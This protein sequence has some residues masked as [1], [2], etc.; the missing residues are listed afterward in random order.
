MKLI[1][2]IGAMICTALATLTALVFCMAMGANSTPA[3]LRALKLWMGG[4]SLLGVAGIVVGIFLIRAGQ[5]SWA[6]IAAFA[7]TVIYGIILSTSLLK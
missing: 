6:A 1:L 3:Q 4:L 7:P 5:P 2:P